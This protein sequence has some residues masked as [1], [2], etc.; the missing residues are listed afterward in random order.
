MLAESHYEGLKEKKV[1]IVFYVISA[2]MYSALSLRLQ[3]VSR[4]ICEFMFDIVP[5]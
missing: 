1:R 5:R 3:F 2:I 4:L